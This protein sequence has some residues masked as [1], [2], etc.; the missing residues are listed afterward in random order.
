MQIRLGRHNA[1]P[2]ATPT[3]SPPQPPQPREKMAG[4]PPA[5]A[6]QLPSTSPGI[7]AGPS[8]L[9]WKWL[10]G[11]WPQ[12]PLGSPEHQLLASALC[13]SLMAPG[14]MLWLPL[15]PAEVVGSLLHAIC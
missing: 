9:L 7:R 4:P 14:R 5:E 6:A 2:P 3:P 8:W 12:L 13:R 15:A 10:S 11:K 1:P